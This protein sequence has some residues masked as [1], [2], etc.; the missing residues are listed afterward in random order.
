MRLWAPGCTLQT[1]DVE[2]YHGQ[3]SSAGL[4]QTT[5]KDI[6]GENL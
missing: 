2:L 3:H 4:L 5:K 1:G 6:A